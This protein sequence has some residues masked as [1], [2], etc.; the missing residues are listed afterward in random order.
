MPNK[1]LRASYTNET[2]GLALFGHSSEAGYGS[3]QITF[4]G[5]TCPTNLSPGQSGTVCLYP[6]DEPNG[7]VAITVK[8]FYGPGARPDTCRE[9]MFLAYRRTD[10]GKLEIVLDEMAIPARPTRIV[11]A[12]D[13]WKPLEVQH[14]DTT[15]FTTWE[16]RAGIEGFRVVPKRYHM[17]LCQYAFSGTDALFEKLC[18]AASEPLKV[19]Q[20]RIAELTALLEEKERVIDALKDKVLAA[21]TFAERESFRRDIA[22]ERMSRYIGVQIAVR[23]ALDKIV[24]GRFPWCR[25]AGVRQALLEIDR[26]ESE[27]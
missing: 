9:T 27:Q 21:E 14:P 7:M 4:S 2:K 20:E 15:W 24:Q 25:R 22:L 1:L 19:G 16:D 12:G 6:G 11:N 23:D 17:L 13:L 26:T 18:A 8:Y 10:K 3:P 5:A